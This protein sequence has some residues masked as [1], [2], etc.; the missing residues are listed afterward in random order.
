MTFDRFHRLVLNGEKA[1]VDLKLV[2]NAFN[3]TAG[4]REKARAELVKDICAMAN[5]G[6]A[7]SYRIIGVGNDRMTVRTVT[8]TNLKSENVQTLVRDAIHPRPTI[9]VRRL[10]WDD[11]PTPF[12]G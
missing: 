5:N 1:T 10:R 8:D 6:E 12:G 11:A 4:D 2:C 7:T 3:K 9:R